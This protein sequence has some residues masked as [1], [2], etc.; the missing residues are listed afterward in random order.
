MI[1]VFVQPTILMTSNLIIYKLIIY[2]QDMIKGMKI[3]ISYQ[4][5][6]INS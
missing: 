6:K 4:L 3:I 2:Y 1:N 5:M